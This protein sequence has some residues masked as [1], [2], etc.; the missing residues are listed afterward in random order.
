MP[1]KECRAMPKQTDFTDWVAEQLSVLGPIRVRS[2]FGGF[3][4]YLDDLFFAIIDEDVLYFKADD[5]N[6]DRFQEAASEP[7]RYPMK[8]GVMMSLSYYAAPE[9]ALDDPEELLAWAR[10]GL[11]AALRARAAKAKKG[12]NGSK[13]PPGGRRRGTAKA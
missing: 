12:S 9:S 13:A 5:A 10:L 1:K 4:V 3:G 2:M 8:D 11:D 6:R 7:F